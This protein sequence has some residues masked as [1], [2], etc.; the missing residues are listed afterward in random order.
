MNKRILLIS[1][2]ALEIQ[3][4][5]TVERII[6][7]APNPIGGASIFNFHHYAL[8]RD[9]FDNTGINIPGNNFGLSLE[10]SHPLFSESLSGN[11]ISYYEKGEKPSGT[12]SSV[13]NFLMNAS[14]DPL[15]YTPSTDPN[16]FCL[17]FHRRYLLSQIAADAAAAIPNL[18]FVN[19]PDQWWIQVQEIFDAEGNVGGAVGPD[20]TIWDHPE[21]ASDTKFAQLAREQKAIQTQSNE[22]WCFSYDVPVI[23]K[24]VKGKKMSNESDVQWPNSWKPWLDPIIKIPSINGYAHFLGA[25]QYPIQPDEN[26]SNVQYFGYEYL[27]HLMDND[28]YSGSEITLDQAAFIKKQSLSSLTTFWRTFV[29]LG[30]DTDATDPFSVELRQIMSQTGVPLETRE[31]NARILLNRKTQAFLVGEA[32]NYPVNKFKG[33]LHSTF[34]NVDKVKKI[35]S[36]IKTNGLKNT[37][38]NIKLTSLKNLAKG[39]GPEGFL[40]LGIN[41][42]NMANQ[43]KNPGNPVE[44]LMIYYVPGLMDGMTLT[45]DT[46]T[47]TNNFHLA[48]QYSFLNETNTSE[49]PV[50]AFNAHVEQIIAPFGNNPCFF[51]DEEDPSS[52]GECLSLGQRRSLND[53]Y[54][55]FQLPTEHWLKVTTGSD[56]FYLT[57]S[58]VESQASQSLVSIMN[59]STTI[60]ELVNQADTVNNYNLCGFSEELFQGLAYCTG[61]TIDLQRTYS[62]G[63][64]ILS[65]MINDEST[66]NIDLEF[67]NGQRVPVIASIPYFSV[68]ESTPRAI[69]GNQTDPANVVL[70]DN[71][72]YSGHSVALDRS[73]PFLGDINFDDKMDS[74]R[75]PAGWTV[76][77]YKDAN[78]KGDYYTRT[79]SEVHSY[80]FFDSISSVKIFKT[81]EPL[82]FSHTVTFQNRAGY[83]ARFL[84]VNEVT[85]DIVYTSPYLLASNNNDYTFDYEADLKIEIQK[86]HFGWKTIKVFS[87]KELDEIKGNFTIRSTGTVFNANASII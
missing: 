68:F 86:E 72:N 73:I 48:S 6:E 39:A 69:Y 1:L 5:P 49:L 7:N 29:K 46:S 55:R 59:D 2:F 9:I 78:Y 81:G 54:Q 19:T 84:V 63:S 80:G 47:L 33:S 61:G 23:V 24:V 77:F 66:T 42:W 13:W 52:K 11:V 8:N 70:Y 40:S 18:G 35:F 51:R 64:K 20:Y 44:S 85:G 34:G 45:V 10:S 43:I 41:L 74:Y 71:T 32:K 76:R 16:K 62:F 82:L 58:Y 27:A 53:G 15:N 37:L 14:G 75:I 31:K 28:D 60:V 67:V 65:V 38:G 21:A 3:A 79:Q 83:N 30:F 4:N 56:T 87:A 22:K 57:T 36:S 26:T 12:S 25:N 50:A 17:Y